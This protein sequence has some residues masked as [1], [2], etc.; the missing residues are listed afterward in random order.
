MATVS[1]GI[2]SAAARFLFGDGKIQII[3]RKIP[4]QCITASG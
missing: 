1:S 3:A 4:M 2:L